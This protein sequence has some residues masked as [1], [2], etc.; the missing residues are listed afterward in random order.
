MKTCEKCGAEALLESNFC[1]ECGQAFPYVAGCFVTESLGGINPNSNQEI[2]QHHQDVIQFSQEEAKFSEDKVEIPKIIL[3]EDIDIPVV[4]AYDDIV[5]YGEE[6]STYSQGIYHYNPSQS[7]E[8]I[9]R[10]VVTRNEAISK[11]AVNTE[12]AQSE[13]SRQ[14]KIEMIQKRANQSSGIRPI[15]LV[16]ASSF[17]MTFLITVIGWNIFG[18]FGLNFHGRFEMGMM[19]YLILSIIFNMIYYFPAVI[20][21]GK[22]MWLIFFVSLF[23]NWTLIA[24]VGC[25]VWAI[26][27]NKKFEEEA[28]FKELMYAQV[29]KA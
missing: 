13:L 15:H 22:D 9:H 28:E 21:K 24:W 16:L 4:D 1:C 29:F 2:N 18:I 27:D 25:I 12:S 7:V 6:V 14:Q 10:P 20:A 19:G 5:G 17:I 8:T 3:K 23:L 26:T 11:T